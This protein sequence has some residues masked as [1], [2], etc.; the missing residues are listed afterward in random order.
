MPDTPHTLSGLVEKINRKG[1][2][3]GG[4]SIADIR[5]LTGR[6]MAG[7]LLFFPA[8]VVVSP[9]SL[10]PTLPTMVAVIVLLVAGQLPFGVKMIWLPK[11]ILSMSLSRERLE[12][13]VDLLRPAAAWI[14]KVS[15]PRLILLTEGIGMRLAA[16]VCVLVAL[17]MPPL[18]FFPG[19]STTAGV[20]I[21]TFGLALTT[22]DGLLMLLALLL[23]FGFGAVVSFW[24]F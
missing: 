8:M 4:I 22:R 15:R 3:A 10:I 17:T 21:A 13:V 1:M 19:A 18:E 11:R 5:R 14:D 24:L 16:V 7:P 12:K 23:V 6:R 9:L 2:A 20:V